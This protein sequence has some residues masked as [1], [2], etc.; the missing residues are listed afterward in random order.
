VVF[1]I[2]NAVLI[3]GLPFHDPQEIVNI[4]T[5]R[6]MSYLD[7]L[8]YQQQAVHSKGL[9]PFPVIRQI[10]AIRRRLPNA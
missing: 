3:N 2:V 5:N 7:Y 1:T 10:L 6:G 8:D 9:P 4:R